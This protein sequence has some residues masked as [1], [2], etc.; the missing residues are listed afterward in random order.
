VF[1]KE[2]SFTRVSRPKQQQENPIKSLLPEDKGVETSDEKKLTTQM[3]PTEHGCTMC[4]TIK[5]R[6]YNWLGDQVG[7]MR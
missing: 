1:Y 7:K 2:F 5:L 4:V 6:M 3:R